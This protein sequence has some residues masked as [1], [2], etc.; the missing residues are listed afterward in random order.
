MTRRYVRKQEPLV[1]EL[2]EFAAAVRTGGAPPVSPRDGM[3]ALLLAR[4]MVEA[5]RTGE[6]IA[7][8]ALQ[9]ALA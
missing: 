7:G 1:V 5:G 9:E 6:V 4:K 8:S 3:V 2:D